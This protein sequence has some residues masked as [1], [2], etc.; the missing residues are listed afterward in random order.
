MFELISHKAILVSGPQRSGTRICSKMIANDTGLPYIDEVDI[1]ELFLGSA[2]TIKVIQNLVDT[3]NFVLHCPPLMPW[4]HLVHGALIVIMWRSVDEI[5]RS[6]E[7]INWKKGHQEFEYNKM[8]YTRFGRL[9]PGFI[10]TD[11]PLA[12]IKYEFWNNYQRDR[13][14][15]YLGVQYSD[16][17]KHPMW[18]SSDERSQFRWNQ[19]K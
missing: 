8:G 18:V 11:I 13:V 15:D 1:S 14:V 12:E 9:R 5:T 10:K 2:K 19:T 6:A 3:K 17:S 16:L 4:I 7:R